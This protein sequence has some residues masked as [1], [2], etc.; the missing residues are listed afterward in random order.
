MHTATWC[1][2]RGTIVACLMTRQ[3]PASVSLQLNPHTCLQEDKAGC[4]VLYCL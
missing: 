2:G 3:M 4:L 1:D